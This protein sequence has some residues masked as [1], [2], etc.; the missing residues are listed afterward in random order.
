V[1]AELPTPPPLA[2]R[3]KQLRN[4]AGLTGTEV[5]KRVG[6]GQPKISMIENG[7][8]A[9]TPEDVEKLARVYKVLANERAVLVEQAREA[10][11]ATYEARSV[12]TAGGWR[13]QDK[14]ARMEQAA[15]DITDVTPSILAGLLQTPT[16]ARSVWGDSLNSADADRAVESR[17]RR[18]QVLNSDRR[19]TF[20]ITEGALRWNL[21]GPD[22]MVG[23]LDRLLSELERDNLRL[24]L[25]PW[26]RTV[27][28]PLL[29]PFLMLD[30]RTILLG[31]VAA[32]SVISDPSSV[33][34]YTALLAT[35]E[36]LASWGED[37]RPH[38]ERIRSEYASLA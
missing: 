29:H 15:S 17:M 34:E 3:L 38:L 30:R 27:T 26:M 13:F 18:Q 22:V 1:T 21:G 12:L 28:E 7:R 37:A 10:R 32:T 19:F 11:S 2:E 33:A 8:S 35:L 20:L 5:A 14:V 36:P 24:G 6:F 25:I 9:P 16:Y 23:Q 31:T 4:A